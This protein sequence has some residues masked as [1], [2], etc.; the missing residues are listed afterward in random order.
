[1]NDYNGSRSHFS[2]TVGQAYLDKIDRL[3]K[4]ITRDET[5]EGQFIV[6]PLEAGI[7]K[8][9]QT[10]RILGEYFKKRGQGKSLRNMLVLKRFKEDV[11]EC[12]DR[13]NAPQHN[14]FLPPAVGITSDNWQDWKDRLDE[15]VFFNV[16]VTTH[17]RYRRLSID[18]VARA[19][20]TYRR[21]TLIVDE[22]LD[23]PMVF[24]SE[25]EYRTA[26]NI[27]PVALHPSLHSVCQGLL[28]ELTEQGERQ[29]KSGNTILRC[30][31]KGDVKEVDRFLSDIEANRLNLTDP[32]RLETLKKF[33][34]GLRVLYTSQ[35]LYNGERI[36]T[37]DTTI[38]RWTL[39]NNIILDAN[40]II[41][42]QYKFD[43][44]IKV[45]RQKPIIDHSNWT[46]HQ[47]PFN[48]SMRN[49]GRTENFF[50][51][52]TQSIV[53][54]KGSHNKTL[55]VTQLRFEDTVRDS[56]NIL[57][58][59][60]I[61][62]AHHG[63]I[64]GKNYWRDFDQV[65]VITNPTYRMETYPLLWQAA[66]RLPLGR[67]NLQMTSVKGVKGRFSFR[68]REFE[69][70]RVSKVVSELYQSIKRINRDNIKKSEVFIVTAD[71]AVIEKLLPYLPGIQVRESIPLDFSYKGAQ[72][73]ETRHSRSEKV[74]DY[75]MTLE[76]GIYSKKDIYTALGIDKTNFGKYLKIRANQAIAGSGTDTNQCPKN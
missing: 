35:C 25:Y 62:V 60:N 26:Q 4:G 70:M 7:G 3:E 13:I 24:F 32:G 18:T 67:K 22:A 37:L 65:W 59:E 1:M 5:G 6:L 66:T 2:E 17:E 9:R 52:I 68:N 30:R 55:V 64:I 45:D 75:L 46:L 20:F 40:G 71:N 10:D 14:L 61:E 48:A 74:A 50:E 21:H 8:S 51:K 44:G 47:V 19:F 11:V 76:V 69:Q 23:V 15:L 12:V 63:A 54:H 39:K 57:G 73:R 33:T 58:A 43:T 42:K 41:D 16:V 72:Q 49:I 38:E 56:L 53:G 31:P 27:L 34:K 36:A 29:K 28:N